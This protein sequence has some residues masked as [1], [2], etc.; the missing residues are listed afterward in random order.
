MLNPRSHLQN[1]SA[2]FAKEGIISP[3]VTYQNFVLYTQGIN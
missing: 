1:S 2:N 3:R